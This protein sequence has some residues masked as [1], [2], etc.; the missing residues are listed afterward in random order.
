MHALVLNVL[1]VKIL[2]YILTDHLFFHP[3]VSLLVWQWA[4]KKVF[5]PL[6]NIFLFN[7]SLLNFSDQQTD[8]NIRQSDLIKY[9]IKFWNADYMY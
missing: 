7:L 6:Q 1:R 8:F 2:I 4:V 5:P 9:N 3:I